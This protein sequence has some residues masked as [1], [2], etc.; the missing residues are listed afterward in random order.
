MKIIEY[1]KLQAKNLHKD[2]N[3]QKL[4]FDSSLGRNLYEYAP[5]YFDSGSMIKVEYSLTKYLLEVRKK[6]PGNVK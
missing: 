5:K 2:F 4:Y 1:F 6:L 3:T